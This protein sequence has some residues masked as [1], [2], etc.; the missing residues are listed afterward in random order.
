MC[1]KVQNG[2]GWNEESE[3]AAAG[4]TLYQGGVA[5]RRAMARSQGNLPLKQGRL[6]G[7]LLQSC[8]FFVPLQTPPEKCWHA[9][10][11]LCTQVLQTDLQAH[12]YA[13]FAAFLELLPCAV[14][15]WFCSPSSKSPTDVAGLP[16]S[17]ECIQSF[18]AC[19][20]R[21]LWSRNVEDRFQ[22]SCFSFP[23]SQ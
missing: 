2:G 20:C 10:A 14:L 5:W 17:T 18:C 11:W 8:A 16:L 3:P 21:V 6:P 1:Q 9:M 13:G 22:R 23:Y 19:C 12:L 4:F 7:W 15:G